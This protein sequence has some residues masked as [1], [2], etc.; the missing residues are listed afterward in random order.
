MVIFTSFTRRTTVLPKSYA[1][2]DF[3][4]RPLPGTGAE[5]EA[6]RAILPDATVLTER[7]ANKGALLAAAGPEILHIA[8]H[9]FF[10]T[11]PLDGCSIHSR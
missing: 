11:F 4:F 9:G 5:G 6:L 3:Y 2:G 10:L 8:T 7:Q 1:F